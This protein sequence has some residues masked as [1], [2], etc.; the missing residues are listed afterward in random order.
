MAFAFDSLG[1]AEHPPG[2]PPRAG[3]PGTGVSLYQAEAHAEAARQFIMAELATRCDLAVLRNEVDV[4]RRE[5][6]AK[7]EAVWR[8]LETKIDGCVV[9]SMLRLVPCRCG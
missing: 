5:L 1:Y 2:R 3:R 7:I 8:E 6:E 9:T 4:L